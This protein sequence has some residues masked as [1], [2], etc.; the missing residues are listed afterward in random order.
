MARLLLHIG[1]YKTA[2]SYIQRRFHL[3]R[4]L[5]ARHGIIYPDIGPNR[6]HHILAT[7]W[8]D[9]PSLPDSCF[10]TGEVSGGNR[11]DAFFEK[12][13]TDHARREGT[14]FLSAEVFGR[15]QPQQIDMADL[16][17]RLAPFEEVRIVYVARHQTDYIQSIWLQIAKNGKAGRFD[18]F[19]QQALKQIPPSGV[20]VDHSKLVESVLA[21]FGPEQLIVM[22]YEAM[23]RHPEGVMGPFLDLLN[24][25]LRASD[26]K[27]LDPQ[28]S[29]ISPD[30]L[31]TWIAHSLFWP[32]AIKP[33]I[34]NRLKKALDELRE[35]QGKKRTTL[36]ARA[37][38][39][40]VGKAFAAGNSGITPWLES[41]P[42]KVSTPTPPDPDSLLFRDDLTE[43]DWSLIL[44]DTN[45]RLREK[46][47]V[48]LRSSARA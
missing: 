34:Y 17:R 25:P 45:P 41:G 37:Q 3:N 48:I 32:E 10:D 21:G 9:I 6:A 43:E 29:N 2:T 42:S 1:A 24:S 8:I 22:D 5:F 38:F 28:D 15:A 20:W 44:P 39:E 40:A 26:L 33:G 46:L 4:E 12:F 19:L 11:Y 14:V 16:A 18:P 36:Y 30:P 23:R 27:E 31:A 47:G 13:V 35:R 7:P